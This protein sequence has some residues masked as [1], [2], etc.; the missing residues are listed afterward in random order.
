MAHQRKEKV[1]IAKSN[2]S[3]S[4]WGLFSGRDRPAVAGGVI[5]DYHGV[6][7]KYNVLSKV[8]IM[9]GTTGERQLSNC[10]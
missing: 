4:M 2:I 9:Y 3:D 5:C 7:Y 6:R 8:M 1:Y 10:N